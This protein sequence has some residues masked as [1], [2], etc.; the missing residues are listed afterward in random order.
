VPHVGQQ[1]VKVWIAAADLEN[2]EQSKKRVFRRALEQIP[3]SVR[4]WKQLIN[5][6]NSP[7]EARV[8]LSRA[9]ELNPLSV[10]LWLAL[11]NLETLDRAK[12]VL[13]RARKTIPT[14]HEIWIAAV[15]LVEKEVT[16]KAADSGEQVDPSF[17]DKTMAG[18]VRIL[19]ENEVSLTREQWL[20]EAENCEKNGFIYTCGAIIKATI[21]FGVEEEDRL[22]TWAEDARSS[23]SKGMV[24]TARAIL[25]YAIKVFPNKV[26]LWSQAAELEKSHGAP[27]VI[28][29]GLNE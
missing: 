16:S 15:K 25:A 22:E 3:N 23:D 21:S 8:L 20:E 6:E 29:P 7:A 14:S 5:L 1:S 17:I 4:L 11:A 9:V 28:S 26:S 19:R 12:A 27:S 2:D 18:G 10:E 24:H 13:N